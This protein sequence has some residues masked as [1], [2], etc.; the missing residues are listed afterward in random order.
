MVTCNTDKFQSQLAD[1]FTRL[2]EVEVQLNGLEAW[3]GLPPEC[4]TSTPAVSQNLTPD[5]DQASNEAQA[6]VELVHRL[7]STFRSLISKPTDNTPDLSST[8]TT[9]GSKGNLT[10]SKRVPAQPLAAGTMPTGFNAATEIESAYHMELNVTSAEYGSQAMAADELSMTPHV[11]RY[12]Y[13]SPGSAP[14]G[15]VPSHSPASAGEKRYTD[16]SDMARNMYRVPCQVSYPTGSGA[17]YTSMSTCSNPSPSV[18]DSYLPAE[19]HAQTHTLS[20]KL[21]YSDPNI[22]QSSRSTYSGFSAPTSNPDLF[23]GS[24]S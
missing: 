10:P 24:Y 14:L 3:A 22:G 13:D 9:V 5:V 21:G 15:F 6:L 17:N 16:V 19:L 1:V 2:N 23:G 20:S 4:F 7:K 8:T 12:A 11:Q 18:P